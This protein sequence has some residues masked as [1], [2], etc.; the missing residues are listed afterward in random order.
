MPP[1]LESQEGNKRFIFRRWPRDP[2][3]KVI[4]PSDIHGKEAGNGLNLWGATIYDFYHV[5]RIPSNIHGLTISTG[6]KLAK[7]MKSFG[8][9][10]FAQDE[11][12]WAFR[13]AE[14]REILAWDPAQATMVYERRVH[15]SSGA[16]HS[17]N[18][19]VSTL[20]EIP[21]AE[22]ETGI[23]I[24]DELQ[25]TSDPNESRNDA[26]EVEDSTPENRAKKLSGESTDSTN[27]V[28]TQ[29]P[30][31]DVHLESPFHPTH[32]PP[33]WPLAP[34]E[35]TCSPLPLQ[36]AIP[37]HLLPQKLYVHDPWNL[38]NADSVDPDTR[39][40]E[41]EETWSSK[42]DHIRT[43]TLS[44][45][46]ESQKM[47]EAASKAAAT[48]EDK[49]Q[50]TAI[51]PQQT[52]GPTKEPAIRIILPKQPRKPT[53]VPEAHLYLSPRGSLGTGHHSIVYEADLELPRDLF[54]ETTYC[55]LC[56]AEQVEVEVNRLKKSGEWQQH[57]S[58]AAKRYNGQFFTPRDGVDFTSSVALSSPV[59]A[60]PPYV[61]FV[62][63]RFE[64]DPIQT[65]SMVTE[66]EMRETP[67]GAAPTQHSARVSNSVLH[68]YVDYDGAV[69]PIHPDIQWQN[70][71]FPETICV[72]EAEKKKPVPRTATFR[73]A[74]K[75]SLP[76]DAHLEREAKNYLKFPA[77]FFQH[78][79]GYNVVPPIHDPTPVGAL[80]P[81]F[82]GY[83]TPDASLESDDEDAYLSPILLIEHCGRPIRVSKL[84]IDDRHECAALLFRFH[85]AGWLHESFAER[86]ILMQKIHPARSPIE[87]DKPDK[88]DTP[89]RRHSTSFRLIDFGRSLQYT[90][91]SQAAVEEMEG[92]DLFDI[93]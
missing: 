92:K 58:E 65:I 36:R 55:N 64:R 4:V 52:E 46:P 2:N 44:L 63:A 24:L 33:P 5:R 57:L 54:C 78:W 7:V 83:Y 88:N 60:P 90:N 13:E 39:R 86:N 28:Q 22:H 45:P 26:V 85:S 31:S 17:I 10:E 71:S 6:S 80:V 23:P 12:E 51:F 25:L 14:P 21:A 29:Q 42:T 40:K 35:S 18:K 20:P 11:L 32:Y 69:V 89:Y 30:P 76:D 66:K 93:F 62:K 87:D 84:S 77:H 37:I 53:H 41:K 49:A 74:A 50:E 59:H 56:L 81:Q 8:E 1:S 72:H 19:K 43:Y 9:L 34:F 27:D 70:P 48:A 73:V 61:G 91:R 15:A 3:G 79:N 38:L 68:T 16:A 47:A 67:P 82:F 75:L